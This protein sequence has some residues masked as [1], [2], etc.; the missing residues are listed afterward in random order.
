MNHGKAVFAACVAL[1]ALWPTAASAANDFLVAEAAPSGQPSGPAPSGQP[2]APAPSDQS[3]PPVPTPGSRSAQPPPTSAQPA[4]PAPAGAQPTQPAA[5]SQ[6]PPQPGQ[7]PSPPELGQR[8]AIPQPVAPSQ[9]P[10][11]GQVPSPP[12]TGQR[13]AIPQPA[14]PPPSRE[15]QQ[16]RPIGG[17]EQPPPSGEAEQPA[18][19]RR[20]RA[21]RVRR[22]VGLYQPR[23]SPACRSVIFPRDPACGLYLPVTFGP[24]YYGPYPATSRSLSSAPAGP[25]WCR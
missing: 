23:V 10:Q 2:P 1:W 7:V 15:F 22:H 5:P 19:Q 14:Q 6:P 12:E 24:Y 9:P 16:T 11:P 20:R 25:G 8:E 13:E 18:P 21:T 4:A 17:M 3:S